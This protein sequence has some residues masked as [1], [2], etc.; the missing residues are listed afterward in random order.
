MES[1]LIIPYYFPICMLLGQ[2]S[3]CADFHPSFESINVIARR[4]AGP[5]VGYELREF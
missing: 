1:S 5:V 2:P 4:A 3:F